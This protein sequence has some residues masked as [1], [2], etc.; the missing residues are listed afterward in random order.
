MYM[1]LSEYWILV[2]SLSSVLR[3]EGLI[4]AVVDVTLKFPEGNEGDRLKGTVRNT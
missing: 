4:K 3:E 1:R 2:C